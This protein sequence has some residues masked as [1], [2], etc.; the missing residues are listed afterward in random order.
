MFNILLKAWGADAER[1]NTDT[2]G[3][4]SALIQIFA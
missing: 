1:T 2:R 4:H 3:V